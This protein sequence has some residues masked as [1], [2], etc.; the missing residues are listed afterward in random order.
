MDDKTLVRRMS[1]LEA[2]IAQERAGRA[3]LKKKLEKESFDRTEGF[4]WQEHRILAAL[5]NVYTHR[6]NRTLRLAAIGGLV[7]ATLGRTGTVAAFGS[8]LLALAVT[9]F[10]ALHA[11]HLL[12]I[13]NE[14]M[15]IQTIVMDAQRR[16]QNFQAEFTS[17]A[18]ELRVH[19]EQSENE[20]DRADEM[21]RGILRQGLRLV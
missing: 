13:Q 4:L 8:G 1:E 19:V 11:N 6:A 17:L 14:K 18:A 9:A 12:S 2:A 10:L 21:L 15:D 5:R 20:K 7:S 3:A 16:T